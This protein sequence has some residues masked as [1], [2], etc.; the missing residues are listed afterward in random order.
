VSAGARSPRTTLGALAVL[1]SAALIMLL[2]SRTPSAAAI[3]LVVHV[4]MAAAAWLSLPAG[5]RRVLAVAWLFTLPGIGALVALS[6]FELAG[7]GDLFQFDRG[8]TPTRA[9]A[10]LKIA[11]QAAAQVP[12]AERLVSGVAEERRAALD[13]LAARADADAVELLRWSLRQADAD[14][15]LEAALALEELAAAYESRRLESRRRLDAAPSFDHA[16]AAADVLLGAIDIGLIEATLIAALTDEARRHLERAL[17]LAPDREV[18][19]VERRARLELV[20]L[21]PDAALAIL[22]P[23]LARGADAGL[24]ALYNDA[25]VAARRGSISSGEVRRAW[26]RA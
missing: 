10:P 16:V 25:A 6:G 5:S 20:A 13:L 2:L 26:S 12:L 15:A 1:D 24:A 8:A 14:L 4:G 21:R 11:R 9:L 18:A 23:A 17:A 3:A 7:E 22:E 19:L